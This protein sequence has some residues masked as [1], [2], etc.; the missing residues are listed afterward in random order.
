ME[1]LGTDERFNAF[2]DQ[3][4]AESIDLKNKWTLPRQR[5]PPKHI[6]QGADPYHPSNPK[7]YYKLQYYEV[8]IF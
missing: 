6:D 7:E 1:S 8:R 5:R 3:V 2:Y 4:E